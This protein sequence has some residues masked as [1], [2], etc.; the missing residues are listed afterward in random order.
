MNVSMVT[1][2]ATSG[3]AASFAARASAAGALG[4]TTS[5]VLGEVSG[6]RD[7]SSSVAIDSTFGLRRLSGL[8]SNSSHGS[9]AKATTPAT[10][11]MAATVR[12]RSRK[13][14]STGAKPANPASTVCAAGRVNLMSAGKSVTL[15]T[16]VSGMP[17]P[18]TNPSSATP[19]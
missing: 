3:S 11:A 10:A 6:S 1:T 14:R 16:K 2:R 5:I 12:A 4:T 19:E 7:R 13:K 15:R 8:K 18:A 9:S 17:M